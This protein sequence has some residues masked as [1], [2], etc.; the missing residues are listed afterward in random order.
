[1]RIER[2]LTDPARAWPP[3]ALEGVATA[4]RYNEADPAKTLDDFAAARAANVAW[5]RAQVNAGCDWA[6]AYVHPHFGPMA[7]G[8]LLASWAAHDALHMRQIAKRLHNMAQRDAGTYGVIYA[9]EW[10]A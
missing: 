10:T 7:A 3:L 8:M 1:M 4:R 9:G 2:T 5:L 6:T